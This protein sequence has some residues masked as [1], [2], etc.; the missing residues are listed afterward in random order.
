MKNRSNSRVGA[1]AAGD[2]TSL[3]SYSSAKEDARP[4]PRLLSIRQAY[5]RALNIRKD[6]CL[7]AH[8]IIDSAFYLGMKLTPPDVAAV[9]AELVPSP[10]FLFNED[11]SQ[12]PAATIAV[13]S[14]SPEELLTRRLLNM[15]LVT[16]NS[17][18]LVEHVVGRA[19]LSLLQMSSL[20]LTKRFTP[21]RHEFEPR[22]IQNL[23][24]K[25]CFVYDFLI[26]SLVRLPAIALLSLYGTKSVI[27]TVVSTVSATVFCQQLSGNFREAIYFCRRMRELEC[28]V[29]LLVHRLRFVSL[30]TSEGEEMSAHAFCDRLASRVGDQE[31]KTSFLGRSNLFAIIHEGNKCTKSVTTCAEQEVAP[32]QPDSRDPPI[33][34]QAS[35]SSSASILKNMNESNTPYR[36]ENY[37]LS[38]LNMNESNTS[39]RNEKYDLSHVFDDSVP[40]AISFFFAAIFV[41]GFVLESRAE[42]QLDPSVRTAAIV[43]AAMGA[44]MTFLAVLFWGRFFVVEAIVDFWRH[45]RVI[46]FFLHSIGALSDTA[47]TVK[48]YIL[49]SQQDELLLSESLKL[50]KATAS[51]LKS[52]FATYDLLYHYVSFRSTFHNGFVGFLV[53]SDLV[54]ALLFLLSTLYRESWSVGPLAQMMLVTFAAFSSITMIL[55][56]LPLTRTSYMIQEGFL[57]FL[58]EHHLFLQGELAS[59][60]LLPHQRENYQKQSKLCESKIAKMRSTNAHIKILGV[61]A[62][63]GSLGRLLLTVVGSLLSGFIRIRGG[64]G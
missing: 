16:K 50:K 33:S 32:G 44:L 10:P 45:E 55:I 20:P 13:F 7:T 25:L 17:L 64:G 63:A 46:T 41:Y 48:G 26:W 61:D 40:I 31:L 34:S 51:D 35:I 59:D 11:G 57:S 23:T 27:L 22:D 49:G 37:D 47:V 12:L 1:A 30:Q 2:V 28:T 6:G 36:I 54:A 19:V 29:D 38:T 21:L 8:D 53:I 58:I 42:Q 18:S 62:T 5:A 56:A 39:Y 14:L 60:D 15:R 24:L 43:Q 3:L 9:L 4:P 52:I